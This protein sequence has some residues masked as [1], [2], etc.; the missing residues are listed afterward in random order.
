MP[1]SRE[2]VGIYSVV[3]HRLTRRS[4]FC[5]IRSEAAVRHAGI[6]DIH[7][8]S[9][10]IRTRTLVAMNALAVALALLFGWLAGRTAAQVVE[11]RL[12]RELLYNTSRFLAE[13][14]LPTNDAVVRDLRRIFGIEFLALGRDA[15]EILACSLDG[16]RA[17][18]AGRM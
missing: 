1:A 7:F 9:L 15:G 16:D 17:A 12:A 10:S 13:R 18:L 14:H 8:M 6:W 4:L 2:Q 11:E 5:P 3:L